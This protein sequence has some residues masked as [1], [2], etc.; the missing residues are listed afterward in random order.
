M[1]LGPADEAVVTVKLAADENTV[2]YL[3]V[4]L[5]TSDEEVGGEGRNTVAE[6]FLRQ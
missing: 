1:D 5:S 4:K 6:S 2:T 3:R